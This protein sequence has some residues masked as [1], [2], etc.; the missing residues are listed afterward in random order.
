MSIRN[1]ETSFVKHIDDYREAFNESLMSVHNIALENF[2]SYC[3]K[4]GVDNT[5]I[6]VTMSELQ[7]NLWLVHMSS[8]NKIGLHITITGYILED[9][10]VLINPI[11]QKVFRGTEEESFEYCKPYMN[12]S[13]DVFNS[14]IGTWEVTEIDKYERWAESAPPLLATITFN[15]IPKG[16]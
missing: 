8:S 2:Q 6:Q 11:G 13:D 5:G 16:V 9:E 15:P 10:Y 1:L 14:K 7:D 4:L 12:L 3:R